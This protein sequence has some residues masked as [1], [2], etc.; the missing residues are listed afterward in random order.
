M[1]TRDLYMISVPLHKQLLTKSTN[2]HMVIAAFAILII[3]LLL[4][5]FAVKFRGTLIAVS[6]GFCVG[7]ILLLVW[8][9]KLL[10]S[11][12]LY[13]GEETTI[14]PYDQGD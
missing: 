13:Y 6:L 4:I 7:L 2:I 3:L 9:R 10:G 11:D 12:D 8:A 14:Y 1:E 5:S